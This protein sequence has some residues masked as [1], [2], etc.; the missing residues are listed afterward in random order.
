MALGDIFTEEGIQIQG[1]INLTPQTYFY[2]A[3]TIVFSMLV[4]SMV[5][6]LSKRVFN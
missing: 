6:V 4:G 2:I 1:N 3:A 5:T